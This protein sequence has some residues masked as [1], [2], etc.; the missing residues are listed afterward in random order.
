M[1][2]SLLGFLEME[3]SILFTAGKVLG[4]QKL[5]QNSLKLRILPNLT[6]SDHESIIC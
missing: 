6:R 5:C 3:A 2:T 1:T 4:Q